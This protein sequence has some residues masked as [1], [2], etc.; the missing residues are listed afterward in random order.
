M[1]P[2]K[3]ATAL[4]ALDVVL[5]QTVEF[6]LARESPPWSPEDIFTAVRLARREALRQQPYLDHIC[7]LTRLIG[8]IV[9]ANKNE[10]AFRVEMQEQFGQLFEYAK[11]SVLEAAK[12]TAARAATASTQRLVAITRKMLQWPSV[13]GPYLPPPAFGPPLPQGFIRVHLRGRM[14]HAALRD[15]IITRRSIMADN[16]RRQT[17]SDVVESVRASYRLR[18]LKRDLASQRRCPTR[19]QLRVPP[20]SET[21]LTLKLE[22]PP[23]WPPDPASPLWTAPDLDRDEGSSDNGKT[24]RCSATRGPPQPRHMALHRPPDVSCYTRWFPPDGTQRY[25][26]DHNTLVSAALHTRGRAAGQT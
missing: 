19:S 25:R 7:I 24:Y 6:T 2:V 1:F 10:Q 23:P 5:E 16:R 15:E 21:E 17:W 20:A 13:L 18:Q 9:P 26:R 22:S 11:S 8:G 4:A 14:D 3:R 12:K